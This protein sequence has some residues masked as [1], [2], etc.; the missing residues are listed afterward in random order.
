MHIRPLTWRPRYRR[1]SIVTPASAGTSVAGCVSGPGLPRR[2]SSGL[3]VSSPAPAGSSGSIRPPQAAGGQEAGQLALEVGI[4]GQE[5]LGSGAARR[6]RRSGI[7]P[8]PAH[9]AAAGGRRGLVGSFIVILPFSESHPGPPAGPQAP[10]EQPGDRR[11][12]PSH[13]RGDLHQCQPLQ[14]LQLDGLPLVVGKPGQGVGQ[15]EE[16]LLPLEPPARRSLVGRQ[17]RLQPRRRCSSAASSDRSRRPAARANLRPRRSACGQ[18]RPQPGGAPARRSPRN[19]WRL[20]GLGSGSAARGRPGRACPA[21]E[22][23]AAP[24]ASRSR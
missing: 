2:E 3:P 22:G 23:R 12:G 21:A 13:P 9:R 8:S 4:A 18:E 17:E 10:L 1:R 20:H 16:R 6:Q 5:G 19:R 11:H 7:R 24:C 15:S 14:V